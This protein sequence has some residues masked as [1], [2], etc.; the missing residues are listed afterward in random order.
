MKPFKSQDTTSNPAITVQSI[1][2]N[3]VLVCTG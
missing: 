2:G 3:P 1:H